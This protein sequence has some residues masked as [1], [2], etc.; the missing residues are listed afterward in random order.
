MRS[1]LETHT[2]IFALTSGRPPSAVS[3]IR[4]SGENIF[5]LLSPYLRAKTPLQRR[6]RMFLSEVLSPVK[7]KIDEA[8][9]LSFVSP[10]SFT[11]EDTLELHCHGTKLIVKEIEK[12]LLHLGARPAEPGEFTYR[13]ILNG[14]MSPRDAEDLGDLFLIQR[15]VDLHAFHERRE[16]SLSDQIDSLRRDLIRLQSIYE[17]AIDFSE[18]AEAAHFVS[19]QSLREIQSTVTNLIHRYEIIKTNARPYKLALVGRPNAGKSSLFNALLTRTRSIVS[20]IPGTTRDSIEDDISLGDDDWKLID[21]AGIRTTGDTLEKEGIEMSRLALR[22]SDMWLLV[23]DAKEGIHP[24][25]KQLVEEFGSIPHAIICNKMDLTDQRPQCMSTKTIPV[26]A[27]TGENLLELLSE[28]RSMANAISETPRRDY[29]PSTTE[30]Q[31]LQKLLPLLNELMAADQAG[32]PPELLSEHA[33]ATLRELNGVTD[34]VT[35][36]EILGRI[37]SDFCIGK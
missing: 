16:R 19:S 2:P 23:V 3:A 35:Q 10:H 12:L 6:R 11:G 27:K 22:D 17:T 21:T 28:I 30:V 31:R 14:K 5:S 15:P 34:P 26:S 1:N 13:A 9:I 36:D 20:D 4:I 8:L 37:F 18:E 24:Q 7:H 33:A 29:L 25:D 32:L